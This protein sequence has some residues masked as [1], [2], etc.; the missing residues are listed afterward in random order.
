MSEFWH[1]MGNMAH[2]GFHLVATLV[3]AALVGLAWPR[4]HRWLDQHHGVSHTQ[5]RPTNGKETR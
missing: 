4:F 5:Q 3:E 1:L 2:W